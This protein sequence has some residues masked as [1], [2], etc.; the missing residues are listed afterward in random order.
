MSWGLVEAE[1]LEKGW[2]FPLVNGA[3]FKSG[4]TYVDGKK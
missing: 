1:V 3:N 4:A 2:G